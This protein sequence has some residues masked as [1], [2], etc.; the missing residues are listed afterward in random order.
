MESRR[1]PPRI[2][3][4]RLDTLRVPPAGKA[5]RPFREAK[6]DRI[7][8]EFDINSFG[9][10]AVCRVDGIPWVVDGQHR[11]YAIQ[12]CGYAKASDTIEC[13]VYEGLSLAEMARM[14]LGRNRSMPVT[15]FERF[16]VA[17]TAG[18]PTEGAITK[19]VES[20]G[21]KI[22]YPKTEGNVYSVGALR[23]VYDRYGAD[24]LERALRV[25]RDAYQNRPAGLGRQAIDGVGL[26]LG[27]YAALDDKLL[28]AALSKEHHGV[29][30]LRRRAEE[31]RER[32]GR[33][34]PECVAAAVVDIYN[35]HAGRRRSLV[36]WWK[37]HEGGHVRRGRASWS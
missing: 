37:V 35:R 36:K 1:Q 11:V 9:Y 6:G 15:A 7:A 14:F 19:I 5:Q 27:T 23:R 4:I 31:Y 30:A 34:V 32:L 20:L 24:T 2:E 28:V 29:Y 26:V 16:G 12:K 33:Q 25:L 10:P 21:L 13:E 17:V 8:A 22:G 18:Y 3:K